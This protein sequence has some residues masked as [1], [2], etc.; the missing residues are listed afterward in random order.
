L[1]NHQEIAWR[2]LDSVVLIMFERNRRITAY[3]HE[4]CRK[5]RVAEQSRAFV[6]NGMGVASNLAVSEDNTTALPRHWL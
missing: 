2:N 1:T 4:D 5:L 3:V 6:L